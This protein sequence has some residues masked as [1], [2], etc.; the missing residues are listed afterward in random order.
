MNSLE[1]EKGKVVEVLRQR[2]IVYLPTDTIP[3]LSCRVLN[4]P[5]VE[6]IY[7]LKNRN[8]KKPLVVLIAD[9]NQ[10]GELGLSLSAGEKE[11]LSG[12]LGRPTSVV[13]K[14]KDEVKQQQLFFLHRGTGTLAVRLVKEN[15]LRQIILQVGPLVS[16]SA[17][18]EG[19]EPIV[20][21]EK[22]WA[23]FGAGVDYYCKVEKTEQRSGSVVAKIN[24]LGEVEILRK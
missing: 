18:E 8:R 7:Q 10:A 17:N 20:T 14:I 21:S 16:T 13:V 23:V 4:R 12:S 22:A 19:K 11:L 3:G 5:A 24:Q 1:S 15:P 9:E 6:K 2:R